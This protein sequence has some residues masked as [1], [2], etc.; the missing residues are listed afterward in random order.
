LRFIYFDIISWVY[1]EKYKSQVV[2]F[3]FDGKVDKSGIGVYVQTSTIGSMEALL[4]YLKDDCKIPVSGLRIGPVHK[5]DVVRASIMINK[6]PDYAVILA[7]DVK[8][9]PEARAEADKLNVRIFEADIIYH[10]FDK[11]SA[12]VGDLRRRNEVEN[13]IVIPCRLRIL[14]KQ[15]VFHKRNPIICGVKVEEG[16]LKKNTPIVVFPAVS[17]DEKPLKLELGT[18]IG[19]NRNRVEFLEAKLGDEVCI[20]IEQTDP[21]KKKYM[22]GRHFQETD[23]LYSK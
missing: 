9:T 12:Y 4:E 20:N 22:F 8:V 14:G 7:F 1:D 15:F 10:F 19:I 6:A 18:I 11:F 3:Y 21:E 17:K 5:K 13:N 2:K 23:L 16:T